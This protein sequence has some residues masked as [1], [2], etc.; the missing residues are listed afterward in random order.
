MGWNTT[1][2]IMNDALNF[3]EK[4]PNFAKN[5]YHAVL[6]SVSKAECPVRVPAGNYSTAALVIETHHADQEVLVRVG[7][8]TGSVIDLAD[9]YM[10]VIEIAETL[11]ICTQTVRNKIL[12][13]ALTA[14][15]VSGRWVVKRSDFESYVQRLERG[16]INDYLSEKRSDE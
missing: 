9:E 15:K 16:E 2:V 14:Q 13:R 4:D 6:K 10:G 8:N 5:L 11:N 7:G 1:V 12:G 3:I